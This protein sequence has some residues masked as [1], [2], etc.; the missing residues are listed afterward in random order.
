MALARIY[1]GSDDVKGDIDEVV[2]IEQPHDRGTGADQ[3]GKKDT[4]A[5]AVQLP[6]TLEE[7]R[8]LCNSAAMVS[9]WRI[10]QCRAICQQQLMV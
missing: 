8:W 6:K 5:R 10:F 7:V 1:V 3:I 2:N 9:A 4:V